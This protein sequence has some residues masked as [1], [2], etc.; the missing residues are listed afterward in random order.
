MSVDFLKDKGRPSH[1]RNSLKQHQQ[2]TVNWLRPP[3]LSPLEAT[4]GFEQ[5]AIEVTASVARNEPA[6]LSGAV[7]NRLTPGVFHESFK[8][9]TD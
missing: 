4:I 7:L 3:D 9:R 8:I 1:S 6:L 5:V 2:T